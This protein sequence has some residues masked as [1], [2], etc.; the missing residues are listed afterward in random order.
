M[1]AWRDLIPECLAG[2]HL[3]RGYGGRCFLAYQV[4]L[5]ESRQSK[6]PDQ[7]R[8]FPGRNQLSDPVTGN[9]SGLEAVGSPPDI[10]DESLETWHFTDDRAEVRCHVAYPRPL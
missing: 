7:L 10:H 3:S 8:G 5:T 2:A 6:R 1:R 4:V 9:R